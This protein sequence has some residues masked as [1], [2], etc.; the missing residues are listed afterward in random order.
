MLP[1]P[2]RSNG[3]VIDETW[4]NQIN[5]ELVDLADRFAAEV[6]G[7]AL[8][9]NIDGYYTKAGLVE[10]VGGVIP[11]TQDLTVNSALLKVLTLDS[12]TGGLEVDVKFKRGAGS[13]TSIFDVL[14]RVAATDGD[15]ADSEDTNGTPAE[16]NTV[17][18]ELLAG[19]LV[20]LDLTEV[21]VGGFPV[22]F[23]L[24]IPYTA[25]GV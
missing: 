17:V 12:A 10:G 19:D 16:I 23:T 14:P 15:F 2:T 5:T 22:G 18:E 6:S 25:T 24:T 3:Q 7:H 9:W 11:I 21:P 4:F 20:R 13:W 1:L 8:A